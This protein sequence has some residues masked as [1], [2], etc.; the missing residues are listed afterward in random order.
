MRG[1]LQKS[2]ESG[3][4]KLVMMK[5]DGRTMQPTAWRG[6][7]THVGT[8]STKSWSIKSNQI[9]NCPK[10]RWVA[11]GKYNMKGFEAKRGFSIRS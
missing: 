4:E 5:R 8:A 1:I 6:L 7:E 11:G 10:S 2:E 3:K 9:K